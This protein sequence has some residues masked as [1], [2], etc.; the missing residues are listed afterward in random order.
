MVKQTLFKSVL[1]LKIPSVTA[2]I[3]ALNRLGYKVL[4]VYK[5]LA[6][7]GL[8]ISQN[9]L[10]TICNKQAICVESN[11]DPSIQILFQS[12]PMSWVKDY[13]N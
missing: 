9:L 3:S 6:I 13:F 5:S 12:S 1:A 10:S 4:D 8:V 7:I 11:P 2:Y